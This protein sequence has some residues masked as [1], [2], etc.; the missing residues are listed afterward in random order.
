MQWQSI[1]WQRWVG[2]VLALVM[3]ALGWS[4]VRVVGERVRLNRE[5]T[6]LQ[7]NVNAQ[8]AEL[9]QYKTLLD[10]IDNFT[11]IETQARLKF[12]LKKPGENVFIV[13]DTL[14]ANQVQQ[15]TPLHKAN[16]NPQLWWEYF[17]G[18]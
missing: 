17:F 4:M 16:G 14:V 12:G 18:T 9:V 3:F 2:V 1:L 11:Y 7:Q 8:E 15:Q 10:K 13:P 5:I 6:T